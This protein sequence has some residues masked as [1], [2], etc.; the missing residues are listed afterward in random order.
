MA[1]YLI[2]TTD[3]IL[4]FTA[5]CLAVRLIRVTGKTTAW[6]LIALAMVFLAIHRGYTVFQWLSTNVAPTAIH[7]IICLSTSALM[8]VGVACIGPMFRRIQDS[9]EKLRQ[10]EEKYRTI[11]ETAHE[12]IGML[13]A[14]DRITY[15][16]Q[17]MSEIFGYS[18]VEFLGRNVLDFFD[19]DEKEKMQKNLARR[20]QGTKE[21]LEFRLPRKDGASVWITAAQSPILTATGHYLGTIGMINDVTERKRAEGLA[22]IRANQQA[23]VATLGQSAVAGAD[24]S[25]LFNEA[26][27]LVSKNLPVEYCK[28][29]ESLPAEKSLLLRA[30]EGW[31]PGLVG[32]AMVGA[33]PDSQAGYTLANAGPV[34]VEDLRTETRFSGPPLLHEHGVVSGLSVII[35]GREQP[36][37]VLGAHSRQRQ[38]FTQDDVNFLQAMANVLAGAVERKKSEEALR[39]STQKLRFLASQ[40]LIAQE[41]ERQ[42]IS[43][44]LH[45]DLGQTLQ[46]LKMQTSFIMQS[47]A[48]DQQSL[49]RE[50]ED[51]LRHIDNIIGRIRGLAWELRPN[52]LEDLGLLAALRHL[53]DDFCKHYG[54]IR[55]QTNFDE[56]DELFPP[57]SQINIFRIFQ[58]A[59]DNIGDHSKATS[60]I[61]TI[62]SHPD[63]IDFIISDNG[64]GFK[65]NEVISQPERWAG[66]GLHAIDERVKILGGTLRVDSRPD[67]GTE[68]QFTLPAPSYAKVTS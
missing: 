10:S 54:I 30:G 27:V 24:L 36:F 7:E 13:D 61:L 14:Q 65:V 55:C 59:L 68:L 35:A 53:I 41:N 58:E 40:L 62:K 17:R 28:V 29:L 15:V 6:A 47:L 32:K 25:T 51:L 43:M 2:L 3:F 18:A 11:V 20:K 45:E 4:Q 67:L 50:C 66:L 56:I 9:E 31:R 48:K 8:V 5:A 26:V 44:E 16:N 64:K 57:S 39:E 46:A 38:S 52:M 42:K 23:A 33:G 12:G 21:I 34:L 63:G 1:T 49:Y 37:G 60:V 19:D 22:N